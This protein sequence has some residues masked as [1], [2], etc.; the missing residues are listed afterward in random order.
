M[1]IL[2]GIKRGVAKNKVKKA[3][4]RRICSHGKN[5]RSW[6][7]IHWRSVLKRGV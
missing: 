2:R 3:G 7:A 4:L 5:D 1:S 6:F